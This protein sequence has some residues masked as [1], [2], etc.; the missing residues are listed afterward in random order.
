MTV[1]TG[2]QLK[3]AFQG[4]DPQD[5]VNDLIDSIPTILQGLA[6]KTLK[7]AISYT[8]SSGTIGTIPANSVVLSRYAIRTTAWNALT[9]FQL[10]KSGSAEYFMTMEQANLTGAAPDVEAVN[11]PIY[12]VSATD[13]VATWNQGAASAGGGYIVIEYVELA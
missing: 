12:I 2:A 8:S 6:I 1:K 11:T 7:V 4:Q 10:G 9:N 5:F 3:A 13:V